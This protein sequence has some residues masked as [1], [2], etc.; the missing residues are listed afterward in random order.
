MEFCEN[1]KDIQ[2]MQERRKSLGWSS[3]QKNRT[4]VFAIQLLEKNYRHKPHPQSGHLN[5]H[6]GG[7]REIWVKLSLVKYVAFYSYKLPESHFKTPTNFMKMKV[8]FLPL[9]SF[10]PFN[11]DV[12]KL[13]QFLNFLCFRWKH[14]YFRTENTVSLFA[15]HLYILSITQTHTRRNSSR[16]PLVATP[17][18]TEAPTIVVLHWKDLSRKKNKFP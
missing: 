6:F 16:K 12:I 18:Q 8:D 11:M 13:C 14:F 2:S 3:L 15:T 5:Y 9:E 7:G 10:P 17:T 1:G 4:V